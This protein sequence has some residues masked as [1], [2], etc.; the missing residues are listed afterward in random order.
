MSATAPYPRYRKMK[1]FLP[2]VCALSL[3]I[4]PDMAVGED[5]LE[6]QIQFFIGAL[7]LDDQSGNW[8]ELAD[9]SVDIDFNTLPTAGI[10]AEYAFEK[11]WVHWGINS[12]GSL[13]WK[14]GDANFSGTLTRGNGATLNTELDN[15]MLLVEV[16]LGG[17]VRGRLHDRITTYAAAGP[18]LMYAQ[19][20]VEDVTVV[21]TPDPGT[22]STAPVGSNADSSAINLGYYA[23]A[24]VDFEIRKNQHLGVGLRYMA[25]ELDFDKTVGKVDFEGP[26]FVLTFTK[27]M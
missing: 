13:A 2:V 17:Y 1:Q 6:P 7:K 3:F 18:L 22:A 14:D 16:H 8:D 24:G 12:G 5:E 9:S 25:S 15:S 4:L 21:E 10:E 26:Q 27:K 11:G 23:R 20:E 19:H